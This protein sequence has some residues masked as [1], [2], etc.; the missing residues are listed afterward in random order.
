M[1]HGYF[2]ELTSEAE[3][4]AASAKNTLIQ[5][6]L[7]KHLQQLKAKK[8]DIYDLAALALIHYRI[9]QKEPNQ[10][11]GLLFLDEAQDFGI[12]IH[13][14]LRTVLPNT[15]FTIM[16]DVSQNIN[17]HTGLN[18]WSQLL[19]LFLTGEKDQFRLLQKSY[20]NTIEISE[21]AGKILDRASSGQYKID[22]VIRHGIPVQ[23]QEFWS[24]IEAAEYIAEAV[25]GLPEKSFSTAAIICMSSEE[26]VR[27]RKLLEEYIPLQPENA[28][29]FSQGTYLLPVN[30]VKGLEFDAVF[31]WNPNLKY[32][33]RKPETAKLLYVAATRALHELHVVQS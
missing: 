3:Q 28:D 4:G 2:A 13:Y 8:Y 17:Y 11:F 12:S 26:A 20:R 21:Y 15:Y 16:G 5:N 14:V 24:E 10:E 30:L 23:E 31:L 33:L 27:A 1:E 32:N 22:P 29:N 19:Q 6:P 25:G 7:Q 18:D 9:T